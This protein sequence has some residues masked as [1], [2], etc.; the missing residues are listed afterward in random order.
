M[1]AGS[2]YFDSNDRNLLQLVNGVLE[3]RSTSAEELSDP[4]LHAHGIKELV[5]SPAARMGYAVVNLLSNLEASKAQAQDRLLALRV[6]YNEVINSAHTSLRL[7]TAR[8]LMQIMKGIV[9]AYGN[10]ERQLKLAHDFHAAANGTPRVVRRL[11]RRYHL[12]EI[13]EG[14]N[15]VAFDDHVY[16]MNTKGRKSPTHLIMDA[17]IKGLRN[18]TIVYDNCVDKEV[19]REALDAARVVG[20]E[21]R[22]GIEFKVPFRNRFVTFVWIPRGF[23]SD[24]DFLSFL[25]TPKMVALTHKGREVI[26]YLRDKLL[27]AIEIWNESIRPENA[28]CHGIDIAPV[29][30]DDFLN[31]VGRGHANREKLAEFLYTELRPQIE[32]RIRELSERSDLNKEEKRQLDVL[33]RLCSDT[34]QDDWLNPLV[35]EELPRINP[36]RDA[37]HMPKLMACTP[38]E[39]MKEL[40]AVTPGC[41]MVLCSSDLAVEDVLELIWD[42]KGAITHLEIF[43][44]R[45]FVKGRLKNIHETGELRFALNTGQAPR[46][47]QMIMQ[48]IQSMR[49]RGEQKRAEKF[50]KILANIPTLWER[51]RN[52]PLKSRVGT[53]AGNRS[54]AFGMGFVVTE[55]LPRR[56]ARYL[57]ESE[58]GKPVIP[59]QAVLE[60]HTIYR[61][62]ENLGAWHAFLQSLH[63]L[64]FCSH[65][66]LERKEEWVKPVG[67]LHVSKAGNMV[68]LVGPIVPSPL[69]EKREDAIPPGRHYLNSN[70][71]NFLKV[72]AGFIPAQ[73]SFMVTQDWW[74]LALFGTIIWFCITGVRNVV[75][76]VL[77][78]RGLS[79]GSLMHWRDQVSWSRL[80][81]SLMYTGISVFLLEYIVRVKLLEQ[82]FGIDV[83][84]SPLLVFS[85]LSIVNGFYILAHNIYRGFPRSAAVGNIFRSFLAIPVGTFYNAVLLQFLVFIGV[86]DVAYYVIPAASIVSKCASDTVGAVIEGIA[87]SATNIRMRRNDYQDKLRSVFDSYTQ[88]ELLFPREEALYQL[89]RTGGL[90][91]R[92]GSGARRLER[93]FIVNALD[94]MYM[95]YYQPRAQDAFKQLVRT[96]TSADRKVLM[97]S[98]LVLARE[99]EVS[100]LM[101]DGLTGRDFAR[102]LA[103]FLSCRKEYLQ[104]MVRLCHPA[105]PHGPDASLTRDGLEG[106]QQQDE[107]TK[108]IHRLAQEG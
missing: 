32:A 43:S 8:V 69:E 74:V 93:T 84:D 25:D 44:M 19:A 80:C 49:E 18:I 23:M 53:S 100:Q 40:H 95:W 11:L 41:R 68:N 55:S 50:E 88:L 42:C 14:W 85:V 65:L 98:Q 63:G 56:G 4:H 39:L 54:R 37:K 107:A 82:G 71:A 102:P 60:K 73:W 2:I 59:I 97:L 6:L 16:D 94:M 66:G 67:A 108:L 70:I 78:A 34:I 12:P 9:R 27:T 29:S 76:M 46:L 3:R 33:Q 21:L 91:G 96:L 38:R 28:I 64:P 99:R 61:Q 103:F 79:R 35:H 105:R 5:D 86:E 75:Q 20:I 106:D 36:D 30:A 62:P 51:Y 45:S 92:G 48:M 57:E 52:Q 24:D 72:L 22:I 13:P 81:D 101:V 58:A 47:K 1:S 89:A 31:Y 77:A 26:A 83:L 104:T 10:E 87:D 17:W 90:K 15:Q 7:N